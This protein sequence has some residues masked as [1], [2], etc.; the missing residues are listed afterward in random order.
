FAYNGRPLL[1]HDNEFEDNRRVFLAGQERRRRAAA[2][3]TTTTTTA[4]VV[5]E[6][7]LQSSPT[8]ISQADSNPANED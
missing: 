8:V 5:N 1:G 4:V 3:T 7:V 2:A 6:P